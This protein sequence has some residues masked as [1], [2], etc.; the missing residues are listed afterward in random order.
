MKIVVKADK[1]NLGKIFDFVNKELSSYNCDESVINKI[2]IAIEEIFVNI[3]SYAYEKD[4][5]EVEIVCE[6][7]EKPLKV[8]IS[9]LDSGKEFNPLAYAEP[10]TTVSLEDR[11]V[12]GLGILLTKKLMDGVKYEYVDG[13]N[14]LKI[15]KE[16]K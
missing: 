10:D 12:G 2:N 16:L 8:E 11:K 3:A 1:S 15:E 7:F 6:I 4:A 5:G 9:F 13:K 14:V